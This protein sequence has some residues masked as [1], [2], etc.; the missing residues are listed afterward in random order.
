MAGVATIVIIIIIIVV[1]D[2]INALSAVQTEVKFVDLFYYY[3]CPA[4]FSLSI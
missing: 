1:I 3:I 4:T 2:R